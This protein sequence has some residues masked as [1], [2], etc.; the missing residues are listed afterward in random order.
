MSN[1]QT[2]ISKDGGI[3]LSIITIAA[4]GSRAV[5]TEGSSKQTAGLNA[6]GSRSAVPGRDLRVCPSNM[7]PGDPAPPGP[8]TPLVD[9]PSLK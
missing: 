1:T 8:G 2:L 5:L 3:F 7:F 9:P 4:L 6:R